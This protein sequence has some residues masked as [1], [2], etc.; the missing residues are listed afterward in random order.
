MNIEKFHA[1]GKEAALYHAEKADRAMIILNHYE[2]DGRSVLEAAGWHDSRDFNLL[3]V[4]NLNWDQEMT[5]WYCPPVMAK[6]SSYAGGADAYLQVLLEDILPGA[7]ARISGKPAYIGIAGYSLA[8]LFA[9][10]ALYRTDMFARA[11]SIS[12]SLWFPDFTV[13]L[14]LMV[15]FAILLFMAF[16][17]NKDDVESSGKLK[18]FFLIVVIVSIILMLVAFPLANI[19]NLCVYII[20]ILLVS[21]I[22]KLWEIIRN[23]K[24]LEPASI[25]AWAEI[26]LFVALWLKGLAESFL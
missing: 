17:V 22:W 26:L 25:V 16:V 1:A 14:L 24:S 12:G 4:S 9:L 21:L 8:G 6:G 11:A 13:V 2:G 3:C 10:Y 19:S 7:L 15:P 20:G 18:R 5:P 23:K